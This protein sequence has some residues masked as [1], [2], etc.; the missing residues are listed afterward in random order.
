[1]DRNHFL[2]MAECDGF[3]WEYADSKL[4]AYLDS[5][6]EDAEPTLFVEWLI[7]EYDKKNV[8]TN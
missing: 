7:R 2:E 1:M 8:E 3:T 6:G 4:D 5:R